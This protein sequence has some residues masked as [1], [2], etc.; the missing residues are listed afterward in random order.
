MSPLS[1][2]AEPEPEPAPAA[3]ATTEAAAPQTVVV[4]LWLLTLIT[5]AGTLAMHIFVPAM[6]RAA[7]DLGAST[8]AIQMT[9]SLYILGL[10]VGQL[11]YGPVSDRFGRRPVLMAGLALYTLAGLAAALSPSVEALIAARLLQAF[12]GC[13]G[14]ALGRAIVR[15]T[16]AGHDAARRLAM[17]NLMV[18]IGPGLA[19][20]VGG[21]IAASLGWRAIFALLCALGIAGLLFTWRRVPETSRLAAGKPGGTAAPTDLRSLAR[22][23]RRL[24]GSP[25]FL[26]YALGGGCATT[27]F[28]AYVAAAPFIFID[29]LHRPAIEVGLYLGIPVFGYSI[30][31]IVAGRLLGRMSID[32]FLVRAN[33]LSAAAALMLLVAVL[34]GW[35]SVWLITATMLV[36]TI[37]GGM[38]SPAALTQ[39]V[40]VNPAVIGSAAGLYGAA[41]MVVGA[42]CSALTALGDPALT[43]A[44]VLAGA[45]VVAQASF[46]VAVRRRERPLV[47]GG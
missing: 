47:T 35:L 8:G 3:Q 18:A 13:A 29:E 27:A 39:A 19:P 46:F 44:L 10:A 14:L 30:G 32:R 6:P 17:L 33:L 21:A 26:G 28:Y 37:G 5:F 41:Q 15:D 25:A 9:I 2:A 45:G 20:M 38:S 16:A 23:Y 22:N 11:V 36:M 24:L 4:P 43:A 12:G 7:A 1:G 31:S 40:S 34:A 42:I